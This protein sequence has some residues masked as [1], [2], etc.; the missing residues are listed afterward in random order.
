MSTDTAELEYPYGTPQCFGQI[1]QQPEDFKVYEQLGFAFT[2]A[3][4]H[5]FLYVQK[6]GLTTHQLVNLLAEETGVPARQIGYSGLKDKNAI[7]Q[8]WLSI[9]LPGCKQIPTITQTEQFQILQSHWHDKKLRVGVHKSNRF[10]IIIRNIKGSVDNI[11]SVVRQIEASGFA[12]YFG[13]QRF[14]AQLDNVEQAIKVLNNRHKCKRLSRTKKGLYLSALRSEL[15]NQ[16]LRQRVKQGI[17]QQPVDGDAFMLSGSQSVFVEPI[18]D[19]IRQ[20]Y[21]EFDIQSGISLFGTGESRLSKQAFDIE[22]EIFTANPEICGTLISQKMK[23]SFR[24]NR[25][26]TRNLKVEYLPEQGEMHMQVELDKG[27]YLTTLLNHFI[28]LS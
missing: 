11:S 8:Q 2:G 15:F 18:S 28:N 23:R 10:E 17:W 4:E 22:N 3:G 9:Q 21:K 5:L 16:I 7:T 1:K 13:Q 19:E 20:R 6:S 24:A 14:G 12:N 27:A 25:M 26:I